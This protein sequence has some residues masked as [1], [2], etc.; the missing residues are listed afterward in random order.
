VNQIL[1]AENLTALRTLPSAS[2]ELIYID[3]PFNTGTTQ[4]RPRLKTIRDANGDR[5]GF[6]G[7]RYRTEKIAPA[8]DPASYLDTFD[9]YLGFLRPRMI[10]AHRILTPTGSLFVHIDPREV[11]Y[12]KVMLDQVFA[13]NGGAGRRCF[14]NEIIWAYDYGARSTRRWPAKHDNILWYT[15]HPTQYTFNLN[16][17]DR[18]PYMAPKLVGDEKAARGKTPTDVWWHTI[19][20][21]TGKEKTGYPTQKPLGILER[22]IRVHSNPGDTVLDFF[23]GSGTTGVAAARNDRRYLL[24][25]QNPDAIT[26]M[27]SRLPQ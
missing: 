22:I 25:D 14:Q 20:S 13:L 26:L 4:K 8:Q 10:E 27:Q 24:I 16:A 3:P 11:H 15:R 21:P 1:H 23:A 9:D 18:I 5:T 6:G 7:H 19:V 12:V 17:T 2:V